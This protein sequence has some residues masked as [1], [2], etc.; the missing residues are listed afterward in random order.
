LAEDFEKRFI[1]PI[2]SAS[3]PATLAALTLTVYRVALIGGTPP[4]ALKNVLMFGAV[5]FLTS[6]LSIFFYS[7]YPTKTRLWTTTALFYLLGLFALFTAV[8][9]IL[10]LPT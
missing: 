2:T 10:V 9:I 7:L 3:Y 4:D 6:S 8:V 5:S 1:K